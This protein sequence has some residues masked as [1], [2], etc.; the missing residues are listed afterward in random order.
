M[1]HTLRTLIAGAALLAP[2][3]VGTAVAQDSYPRVVG[4]GENASVEY[5]PGPRNNVVGGGRVVVTDSG[6]NIEL[7]HLD[8]E[9]AQAPRHNLAPR[10]IG[11]GENSTVVYLPADISPD[12]L[13][14]I[15]A[16]GSL[17]AEREATG[18]LLARILGGVFTGG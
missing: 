10:V 15:G 8:P 6:E 5:G 2:A 4:T 14:L 17:P 18:G 16:D 12:R 3:F 1:N 7:R 13:A 9:F 11:I